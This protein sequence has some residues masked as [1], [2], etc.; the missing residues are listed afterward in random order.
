MSI[1]TLAWIGIAVAIGVAFGCGFIVASWVFLPGVEAR[2]QALHIAID[3]V[4]TEV[5]PMPPRRGLQLALFRQL[6]NKI[7]HMWAPTSAIVLEPSR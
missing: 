6:V 4:D 7:P 3:L 2:D 1:E 5:D